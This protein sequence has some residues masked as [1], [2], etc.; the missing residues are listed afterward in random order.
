MSKVVSYQER[1]RDVPKGNDEPA[2]LV[3]DRVFATWTEPVFQ[4]K[5]VGTL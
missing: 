3:H 1:R 2:L 5:R 4:S